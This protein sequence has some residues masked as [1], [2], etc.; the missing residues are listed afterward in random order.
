MNK[1]LLL[2]FI[3]TIVGVCTT[4]G[5][6][7]YIA[8]GLEFTPKG[9]LRVLIV[10]IGYGEPYDSQDIAGW[11]ANSQFPDWATNNARAFYTSFSDFSNNIYSDR[12]RF[13]V[14]NFYY[15]MSNGSFRL[16]ADYYPHRVTVDVDRG[17]TWGDIHRKAIEQIANDVEWSRYDNRTNLPSFLFD[18]SSSEPDGIVD[19]IVF[20]NRFSP[21]WRYIPSDELARTASNGISTTYLHK[22]MGN[23]YTVSSG[24][25]FYTGASLPI[26]IFPHEVGHRLYYG[27]HYGGANNV[28]GNYF[29][30]PSAG[31]GIMRLRQNYTC[32]AGWERYI[33][34]WT[35]QIKASGENSDIHSLNDLSATGGIFTL[36]DFVTSGDALRIIVPNG[37]GKQQYLWL[38]NHQCLSTFDGNSHGST[39]CSS[40]IDEYK[41]GLVAYVESYSQIKEAHNSTEYSNNLMDRSNGIRWISRDGDYDFSFDTNRIYPTVLCNTEDNHPNATYPLYKGNPNPI[42]GQNVNES[43]RHDYN[44]DGLIGYDP[45]NNSPGRKNEQIDV[46]Q[47]DNKTPTAR[48]FTGSGM[49]FQKGD[50]VSI[51]RN[52]CVRN[53]PTYDQDACK[54]GDFFLNGISFEILD[55]NTDGSMVVKVRVDD[56][57]IDTNTRWAA[58]SIVLTDITHDAR[59]DVVV[60]PSVCVTIDKSGTPNRH[61][62]PANPAQTS[63]VVSDFITP[64]TLTC[65]DGS[66]F[67]Q[68]NSST[69]VVQNQSTLVLESGSVYEIG[70]N[71][72]LDIKESGTLHVKSGATLRVSG[73]G[74]IDVQNGGYIC[75]EDGADIQLSDTLSSIVL[76]TGYRSGVNPSGSAEQ[77]NCTTVALTNFALAEPSNGS[78]R[79]YGSPRMY[80]QNITYRKSTYETGAIIKAGKRVTSDRQYGK[81][82]VADG[83]NV[84]FDGDS[85]V[86]LE[87]GVEVRLG[88]R[89]EVR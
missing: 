43:I 37:L 14:S 23:G 82:V 80:I 19:F 60:K 50:K 46:V 84:I 78:V 38:E 12:N 34:D 22:D 5:Q 9:D 68:E 64:T 73:T 26:E 74:W 83:A 54:T 56:V 28:C 52:P 7:K 75:V 87:P 57:D 66:Y 58:A 71:A 42:G 16:I 11:P 77:G 29:Y 45:E 36:R 31:W 24:F 65:R 10:F 62:N 67:K 15:Q 33:L 76:H 27:P 25:T 79:I 86:Y 17:D 48:Y 69:V 41:P 51:A 39:F 85:E 61:K 88:G 89:L 70:D 1:Q 55:R 53:I 40:P 35:P 44:N 13:S 32:A 47:I 8:N 6:E 21:D 30:V 18:N 4:F 59:P 2:F 63:S 3:I 81:V 20:C 49:Q 72:L